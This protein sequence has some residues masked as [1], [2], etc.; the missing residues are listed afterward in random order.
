MTTTQCDWTA[1]SPAGLM[2]TPAVTRRCDAHHKTH[3]GTKLQ[4][5]MASKKKIEK[6]QRGCR[7]SQLAATKSFCLPLPAKVFC[8]SRNNSNNDDE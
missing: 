5:M 3:Q 2:M 1:L 8:T 4:L 7:P 6:S